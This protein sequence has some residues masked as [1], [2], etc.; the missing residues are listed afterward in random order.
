MVIV[1]GFKDRLDMLFI[2]YFKVFKEGKG[3]SVIN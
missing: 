2:G 1:V 3:F